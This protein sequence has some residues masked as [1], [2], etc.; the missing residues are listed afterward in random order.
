MSKFSKPLKFITGLILLPTAF[1]ILLALSGVAWALVKN[2][3]LSLYFLIGAAAYL[4]LHRYVY[5]FSRLYVVS[6]EFTH[7]LAA[8]LTGHKVNS[9][10]IKEESGNVKLSGVNAFILLAPY[11]FPLLAAGLVLAYYVLNFFVQN[12]DA[13]IFLGLFGFFVALHAAHTYKSLTET[14]QSDVKMAGGGVFSFPLIILAN[15]VVTALLLE[16]MLPRVV[17]FAAVAA[18]VLKNTF[19]FWREFFKQAYKL[20]SWAVTR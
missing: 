13:R 20:F 19:I 6:H 10:T 2:I 9:V 16:L 11:C 3:R 18:E 12:L 8:L 4:I 17:P 15:A 14:E 5:N 1:F 7:A